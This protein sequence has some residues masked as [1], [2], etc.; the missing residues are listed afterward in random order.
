MLP[1]LVATLRTL[2]AFAVVLG[3]LVFVHELGHYLAARWR[4]VRVEVFSIGFGRAFASWTDRA[5]TVWKL[6]WLP[7]GGYV[8]M[9]GQER[10]E[11]VAPEVRARW[12]DGQTFQGKPVG[13]RVLIVAAGPAANF[14]LAIVLFTGL[15]AT[16]GRPMVLP[17][18]GG[19]V[20]A[21]A[22]A[23]AGLHA[24]DRVLAIDGQPVHRFLDI[25][26]IVVARPGQ[27]V[28]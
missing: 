6:A 12:I 2:V 20:P 11:D 4:G 1:H 18:V 17:E 9:H 21:S 5:G 8:K 10:P 27:H 24:G 19:V 23:A 3:I 14:V 26:H 13:S 28:T 15:F 16:V 25:Q 7:L 22:A